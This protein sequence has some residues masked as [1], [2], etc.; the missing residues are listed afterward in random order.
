[1]QPGQFVVTGQRLAQAAMGGGLVTGQ[2]GQGQ[3]FPHEI[4]VVVEPD[5]ERIPRLIGD[6]G[7]FQVDLDVTDV[8]GGV[9][10]GDLLVHRESGGEG[11]LF[12]VLTVADGCLYRARYAGSRDAG[13]EGGG[14]CRNG[15]F[16][17]GL[18][19]ILIIHIEAS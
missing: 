8:L 15:L 13:R 9:A 14:D 18:G 7:L 5:A 17:P 4:G 12:V 11:V 2:T 10:A 16:A 6:A 3:H 1:M 19:G